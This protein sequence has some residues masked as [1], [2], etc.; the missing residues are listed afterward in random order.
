[1]DMH[2]STLIWAIGIFATRKILASDGVYGQI[3]TVRL[4]CS[5]GGR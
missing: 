5:C 4:L 1:M 3:F 2:L